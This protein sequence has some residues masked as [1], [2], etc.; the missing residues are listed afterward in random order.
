MRLRRSG[1]SVGGGIRCAHKVPH[2]GLAPG[3][4]FSKLIEIQRQELL[5]FEPIGALAKILAFGQNFDGWKA[6][7]QRDEA[8]RRPSFQFSRQRSTAASPGEV[9]T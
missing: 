1:V 8:G 3:S 6:A 5:D 2:G 4:E 9:V 7:L